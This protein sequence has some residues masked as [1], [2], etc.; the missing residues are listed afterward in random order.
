MDHYQISAQQK[1]D[2]FTKGYTRLADAVPPELLKKWQEKARQLEEKAMQ[3]HHNDEY[4]HGVCIT[5]DSV[6]PRLMR[7]DDLHIVDTE[8]SLELLSC[9]AM[10]AVARELCGRG[11]VPLQMDLLYKQQH[12]HPVIKWHQGAPHPRN[13]PYLNIGVYLDDAP[14]GDGCLRYVAGTQHE[15]LDI[16]QVSADHGWEVPGVVELPAKAGDILIQDMMILHGSQPK[17]S[18]GTRRTIYIEYR[19]FEGILESG[20]QP[21]EWA[22]L[23]K[24][25]MAQVIANANN[26]EWPEEWRQDYPEAINDEAGLMAEI[27]EK[28]S[29]P[30]PA[31]WGTK[32]IESENYPVPEDMK[33]W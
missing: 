6:G 30:I 9:P 21:P 20:V 32:A 24:Q 10:M 14:E 13:Y 17:R 4:Q 12:P 29:P 22:E 3:A 31:V 15:L 1:N 27:H 5:Q 28:R 33:N 16:D 11:A 25:W 19:P 2:Y 8:L 18:S 7:Y 26:G 23:R